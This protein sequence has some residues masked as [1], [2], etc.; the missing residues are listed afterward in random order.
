MCVLNHVIKRAVGCKLNRPFYAY[1]AP[2]YH[3]AKAIAWGYLKHYTAPIPGVRVNESELWIELPNSAR[4]K[5]FGADNP[6]ALRGLYFDGVVFDEFADMRPEAWDAVVR[7]AMV[8][9]KGWAVFIG[10]PRGHNRFYDLYQEAMRSPDWYA[11]TFPASKTGVIPLDELAAAR[12]QM[13]DAMYRQ[14]FECDWDV[15]NDDILIPLQLVQESFDRDISY[16]YAPKIMGVDVGMSL[17]GDPSAIVI[18]QGGKVFYADEFRLDDTIAIAGK[19]KE[20]YHEH[21]PQSIYIDAI[22]WG[23]GVAHLCSGWGLPV[24]GIN[25]GESAAQSERFNRSR[26]ELWW[27][28]REFFAGKQCAIA[29]FDLRDKLAAEL[30]TPTYGYLP[31]GKIKVEGKPELKKRDVSSPNLADALVLTMAHAEPLQTDDFAYSWQD[32]TPAQSRFV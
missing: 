23:A 27:R 20:V 25:V 15:S 21:K 6:D 7:P 4:I 28:C 31:T 26:D 16:Y 3:Q 8:D 19:V 30:S 32:D 13:T 2:F 14:E 9:R 18:R 24:V 1:I 17:G 12:E 11:A 10:T 29:P 5:L 22:S